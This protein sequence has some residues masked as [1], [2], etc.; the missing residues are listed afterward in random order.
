[1]IEMKK[2]FI[3][4]ILVSCFCLTS[5]EVDEVPEDD[6]I[7]ASTNQVNLYYG[8][9]WV[10][11]YCFNDWSVTNI[12]DWVEVAPL[13]GSGRS[14]IYVSLKERVDA[15]KRSYFD[16]KAGAGTFN[17]SVIYS[18]IEENPGNIGNTEPQ[19]NSNCRFEVYNHRIDEKT[20]SYRVRL[21]GES[22]YFKYYY[23]QKELTDRQAA[24]ILHSCRP[25]FPS[26]G[27]E[28]YAITDNDFDVP[29]TIWLYIMAFDNKD[30]YSGVYSLKIRLY[31]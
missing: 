26:T 3:L 24:S 14:R 17:I 10:D 6:Y 18:E 1:M 7:A 5:C 31:N 8:N 23:S 25:T 21:D 9:L 27:R 13:E 4:T 28:G 11:V 20:I 30:N 29:S 22:S 15:P 19:Y 2:F 16:L 12:P